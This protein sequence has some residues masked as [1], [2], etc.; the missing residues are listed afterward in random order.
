LLG[1]PLAEAAS[2]FDGMNTQDDSTQA[3]EFMNFVL[4]TTS[5]LLT[6]HTRGEKTSF[7]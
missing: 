6:G 2:A 5:F 4:S 1:D 7:S 3:L